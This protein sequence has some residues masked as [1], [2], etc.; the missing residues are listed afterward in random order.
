ML[1]DTGSGRKLNARKPAVDQ[2]PTDFHDQT[3]IAPSQ[4]LF[5][6]RPAGGSGGLP[7]RFRCLRLSRSVY[8]IHGAHLDNAPEA[9]SSLLFF[10]CVLL[11]FR[12]DESGQL[13]LLVVMSKASGVLLEESLVHR[14]PKTQ[15]AGAVWATTDCVLLHK[16]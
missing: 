3:P 13:R 11:V 7:V 5:P 2:N 12:V 10:G 8:G 15:I 16:V 6:A 4:R 9:A 14:I 1:H